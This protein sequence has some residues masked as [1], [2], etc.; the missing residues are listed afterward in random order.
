MIEGYKDNKKKYEEIIDYIEN[1]PNMPEELRK[2]I[3]NLIRKFKIMI[4]CMGEEQV[5][6]LIQL[7][8][9]SG[10]TESLKKELDIMAFGSKKDYYKNAK[11]RN[12]G[13]DEKYNLD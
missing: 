11:I 2:E 8:V 7:S 9:D 3:L 4:S 5:Y 6:N 12:S 13:K 1:H 10:D